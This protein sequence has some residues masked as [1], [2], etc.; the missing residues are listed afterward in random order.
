MRESSDN[1]QNMIILK[2]DKIY[3]DLSKCLKN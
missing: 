2:I 1:A 3:I